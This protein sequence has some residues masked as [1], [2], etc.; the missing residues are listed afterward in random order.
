MSDEELKKCVYSMVDLVN[1]MMRIIEGKETPEIP[2]KKK[3]DPLVEA[4]I[5]LTKKPSITTGTDFSLIHA[6]DTEFDL[7]NV[8]IETVFDSKSGTASTGKEWTKQSIMISD[9]DGQQRELI[10][11]GDHMN[12]FA[13]LKKGQTID[14]LVVAK[15]TEYKGKLQFT[16]GGNS[17]IDVVGGQHRL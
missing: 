9:A 1:E 6:K 13:G 16:L 12:H 14:V 11:W 15:C 10:A 3:I 4:H 8:T 17:S 5:A 7:K 2:P